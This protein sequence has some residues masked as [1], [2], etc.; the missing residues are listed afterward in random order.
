MA[1]DVTWPI[2]VA[3]E[4]RRPDGD[5]NCRANVQL[6]S[7]LDSEKLARLMAAASIYALPARYEPFGLSILEAALCGCALVLGDIPSLREVW[8]DAALFVAPDDPEELQRVLA[9][10]I[11]DET[12]RTNYG[13]RAFQRAQRYSCAAVGRS[14]FAAY[15][16]LTAAVASRQDLACQSRL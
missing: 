4:T 14:Y 1:S 8:S 12:R 11:N 7:K 13:E 2:F 15:C 16:E 6:L 3:G 10:L 9:E 5:E